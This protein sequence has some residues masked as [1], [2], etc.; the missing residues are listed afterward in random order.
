[1]T[2]PETLARH[3]FAQV[4]DKNPV[5]VAACF[6]PEGVLKLPN[7]QVVVG[8]AAIQDYYRRIFAK[9]TPNPQ[10]ISVIVEGNRCV[11]EIH[12]HRL[13]GT[14][15]PCADVFSLDDAG[16]VVELAIYTTTG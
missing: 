11:A 15:I 16:A 1:M 13:D 9:G 6:T 12:A 2:R 8:R 14:P 4:R 7:G 5:G 10:V 3:Y